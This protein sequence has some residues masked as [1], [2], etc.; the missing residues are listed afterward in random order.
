MIT[1]DELL[2]EITAYE[3]RTCNSAQDDSTCVSL[4]PLAIALR[5]VVEL[6]KPDMRGN[7][8]I[9]S[10]IIGKPGFVVYSAC[11]TIQAIEEHL[12]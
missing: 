3:R 12:K 8:D 5:A 7:C 4:H 1:H 2:E 10:W 6:H 9:C 11:P